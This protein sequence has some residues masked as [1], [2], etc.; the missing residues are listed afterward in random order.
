MASC[1][2]P[3]ATF[4]TQAVE[5]QVTAE[6]HGK[7]YTKALKQLTVKG[8]EGVYV[9]FVPKL[10]EWQRIIEEAMVPFSDQYVH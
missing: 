2:F 4:T 7:N 9:G 1:G 8:E 10:K 3:D 5:E 6:G